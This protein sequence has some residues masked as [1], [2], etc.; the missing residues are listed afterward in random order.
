MHV[1]IKTYFVEFSKCVYK[2]KITFS[3][4]SHF[5]SDNIFYNKARVMQFTTTKQR[6]RVLM[7]EGHRYVINRRGKHKGYFGDAATENVQGH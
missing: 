3:L 5:N 2:Y 7:Y 6:G 1:P 4:T